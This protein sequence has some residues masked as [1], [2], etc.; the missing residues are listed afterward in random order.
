MNTSQTVTPGAGGALHEHGQLL[1]QGG[2]QV[3]GAHVRTRPQQWVSL[4][5]GICPLEYNI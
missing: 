2:G 1:Q 3:A 5:T 4:E